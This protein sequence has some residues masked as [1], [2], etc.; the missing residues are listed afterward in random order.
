LPDRWTFSNR[1]SGEGWDCTIA[2]GGACSLRLL[3]NSTKTLVR[4]NI[5]LKGSA[6]DAYTLDFSTRASGIGAGHFTVSLRF[7]YSDGTS[8]TE[9]YTFN[10][11]TFDWTAQALNITAA[12]AYRKLTITITSKAGVAGSA[13]VDAMDLT[14]D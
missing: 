2:A 13:W 1:A 11:G 8:E 9:S 6:G 14:L 5:A 7:V 4:Q 10:A 12:K 3:G